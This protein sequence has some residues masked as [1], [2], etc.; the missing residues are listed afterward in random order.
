M[1]TCRN[2]HFPL[3]VCGTIGLFFHSRVA[4]AAS[5]SDLAQ[6]WY[7]N[8]A[9]LCVPRINSGTSE[10]GIT[11]SPN[12]RS[13]QLRAWMRRASAMFVENGLFHA[14]PHHTPFRRGSRGGTVHQKTLTGPR[15]T[16]R[17]CSLSSSTLVRQ[18][19]AATTLAICSA[20]WDV[21]RPIAPGTAWKP[22]YRR[23]PCR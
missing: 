23:Q 11:V 22:T 10:C 17:S 14:A 20:W 12:R 1:N 18:P 16:W 4:A 19:C 21:K 6:H 15:H 8:G 13:R 3:K 7:Y 5:R 2:A 9:C